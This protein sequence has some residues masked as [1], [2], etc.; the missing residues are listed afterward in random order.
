MGAA[1]KMGLSAPE[2]TIISFD[3]NFKPSASN[4]K[5]PSI[6]PAYKGPT[7][8]CIFAR[9][10]R[11]TNIVT[12]AISAA[13]VKPGK[14]ATLKSISLHKELK[15]GKGT[16]RIYNHRQKEIRSKYFAISQRKWNIKEDHEDEWEHN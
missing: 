14:T 7:L 16:S 8:S 3:I 15:N 5:I 9:N 10:F 1:Q 4:W 13:Y 6:L 11:S 2:G 12:A